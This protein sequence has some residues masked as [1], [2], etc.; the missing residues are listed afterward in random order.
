[1]LTGI[2][3]S[4]EIAQQCRGVEADKYAPTPFGVQNSVV[5]VPVATEKV[6]K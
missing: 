5:V 2:T 1:M 4:H 3:A 6:K